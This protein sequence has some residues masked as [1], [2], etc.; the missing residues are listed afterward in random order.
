MGLFLD[1]RGRSTFAIGICD[2][3]K[4]KFPRELL[5]SDSNS[6]GLLVCADDWDAI[7]PYRLPARE[8]ENISLTF[9][10]PD[11]RFEGP[12]TVPLIGLQLSGD[13][14]EGLV[15]LSGDAQEEG[16]DVLEY[17]GLGL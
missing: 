5:Y 2:R 14:G 13:A 4:R 16:A 12:V 1:T 3:C 6:P 17:S 8:A 7:D 11:V 9:T 15:L 10:R